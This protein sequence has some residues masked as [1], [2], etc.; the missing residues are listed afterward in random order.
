MTAIAA[1][2]TALWDIK[3]KVAGLP[4]YQLL[5]GRSRE[6]VTVYGHANAE[7]IDEVLDRGRPATSSWATRRCG[8]RP[9]SP[10]WPR[11]TASAA[12]RM[13]YEP[14]D[15]AIPPETVWSTEKYL[16]H[17]PSVFARVRD[18]FGPQLQAAARRPPPAHP[19]RGGAAGQGALSRTR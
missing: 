4:V 5:G 16:D 2:D 17:V 7:T 14:A 11:R 9:A 18:E 6:G 8:C 3:G 19:D 15:A 13:F 1:V 12:D 10:A